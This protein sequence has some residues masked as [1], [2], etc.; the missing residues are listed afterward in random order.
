MTFLSIVLFL[1]VWN[2]AKMLIHGKNLRA[3]F[4]PIRVEK[5]I[6]IKGRRA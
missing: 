4:Q 2:S 3:S 5:R 6:E 1:S